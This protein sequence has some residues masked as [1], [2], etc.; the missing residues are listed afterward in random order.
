MPVKE[1][2]AIKGKVVAVLLGPGGDVKQVAE[3]RNIVTNGGDLYYAE[4]AALL[5]TGTPISPVPT[6]FTDVN[7]VP[8]MIMGY[9]T[10]GAAPGKTS[11]RSNI[12]A[13]TTGSELALD[14]TYPL[15]NDPDAD[16]TGSGTDIVT[17]HHEYGAGVGTDTGIDRVYLTNP[18]P[19]PSEVLLM[20]AVISPV[21]NKGAGDTLK[22]FVNHQLNGV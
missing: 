21:I 16:N 11:D 13:R 14:A 1:N 9:G 5:T 19:G 20:Y 2:V 10:A 18:S 12:T 6:N 4:R 3:G 8:D 22:L 7:G 17:Y 15:V